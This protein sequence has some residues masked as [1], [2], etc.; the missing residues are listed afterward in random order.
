M[1]TTENL[2]RLGRI[3]DFIEDPMESTSGTSRFFQESLPFAKLEIEPLNAIG[4][5]VSLRRAR[6]L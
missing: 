5:W 6:L 2:P 3:V 4:G 1:I